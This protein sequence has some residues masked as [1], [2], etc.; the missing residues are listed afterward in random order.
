MKETTKALTRR[1]LVAG[2]T[3]AA[4]APA[5]AAAPAMTGTTAIGKLWQE[6]EAL[7]LSLD[8]HRAEIAEA[9]ALASDGVPGWMRLAGDAN[10]IGEARYGKLTAILRAKPEK[11]SDLAIIAKVSQDADMLAGARGWAAERL[12][13][14]SLAL[15]A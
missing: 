14:A 9:A 3:V 1:A 15:A 6:A 2:V 7:R 8:A 5:L 4:A 13:S 12:A 11:A 10:R